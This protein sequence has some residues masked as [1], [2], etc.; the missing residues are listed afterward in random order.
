MGETEAQKGHKPDM[1]RGRGRGK[2][3][4]TGCVVSHCHPPSS[5]LMRTQS[6]RDSALQVEGDKLWVLGRDP[7]LT[8]T[9][10]GPSSPI[11][12][13]RKRLWGHSALFCTGSRGNYRGK[14]YCPPWAMPPTM[15]HPLSPICPT[16]R[17]GL[18]GGALSFRE[19]SFRPTVAWV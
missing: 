18:W 4:G 16:N 14:A 10:L 13:E 11:L 6:L 15:P 1:N 19:R 17:L 9:D 3:M 7:G 8:A 2:P 5:L 12:G